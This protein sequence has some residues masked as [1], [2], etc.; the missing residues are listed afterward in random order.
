[1]TC[2]KIRGKIPRV[3]TQHVPKRPSAQFYGRVPRHPARDRSP[4]SEDFAGR[5]RFNNRVGRVYDLTK[6]P[7]EM[8]SSSLPRQKCQK[9]PTFPSFPFA[10]KPEPEVCNA[11][12]PPLGCP[13]GPC[14]GMCCRGEVCD[15]CCVSWMPR[16][17]P[18][19]RTL[20]YSL[21]PRCSKNRCTADSSSRGY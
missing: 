18:C 8:K 13:R 4:V 17:P 16:E 7:D 10:R 19:R 21:M 9:H 2:T 6:T 14:R 3:C 15:P 11:S 12:C 1:M 20:P 5:A